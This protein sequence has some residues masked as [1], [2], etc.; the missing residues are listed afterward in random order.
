[1]QTSCFPP[2]PNQTLSLFQAKG[3]RFPNGGS[4]VSVNVS[5]KHRALGVTERWQCLITRVPPAAGMQGFPPS[6][7]GEQRG[8]GTR[9]DGQASCHLLVGCLLRWVVLGLGE[10]IPRC[11]I[12][13]QSS[14]RRVI[15]F[16]PAWRGAGNL[17]VKNELKSSPSSAG[18]EKVLPDP[19]KQVPVP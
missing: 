10:V 7:S 18:G 17:L 4:F 19:R 15:G 13:C 6:C 8:S 5:L 9:C 1:M 12:R 14:R 2:P 16:C 11:L 3:E